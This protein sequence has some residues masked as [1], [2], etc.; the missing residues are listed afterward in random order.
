MNARGIISGPR[1]KREG[2]RV[3]SYS[4]EEYLINN[5]INV[6]EMTGK[7]DTVID[8][9]FVVE[10]DVSKRIRAQS[11]IMGYKSGDSYGVCFNDVYWDRYSHLAYGLTYDEMVKRMAEGCKGLN[12]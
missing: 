2:F 5:R 3:Y 9:I 4:L 6:E 7:R 1:V 12:H 8:T 10:Y 11:N